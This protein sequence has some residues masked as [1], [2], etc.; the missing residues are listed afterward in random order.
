MIHIY[1]IRINQSHVYI[2]PSHSVLL[3]VTRKNISSELFVLFLYFES[4]LSHNHAQSK[5]RKKIL[6]IRGGRLLTW[7]LHSWPVVTIAGPE[8]M[9]RILSQKIN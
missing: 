7:T 3:G 9:P 2:D 6:C 1:I 4:V 5:Y 8:S